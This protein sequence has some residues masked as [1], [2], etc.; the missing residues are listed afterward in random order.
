MYE[1]EVFTAAFFFKYLKTNRNLYTRV[2]G[3][4]FGN[5]GCQKNPSLIPKKYRKTRP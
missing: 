3:T 5:L 2:G 4:F 1:N